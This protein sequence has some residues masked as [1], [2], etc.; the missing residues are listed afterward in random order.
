MEKMQCEN[1]KR[2]WMCV[3]TCCFIAMIPIA[4]TSCQTTPVPPFYLELVE[5]SPTPTND[6]PGNVL[7]EIDIQPNAKSGFPVTFAWMS[8][9]QGYSEQYP[10][11]FTAMTKWIVSERDAR[12]IQYILHTGD[13][14]DNYDDTVQ[15]DN[16]N[17]ALSILNGEV[18][19][20]VTAGNHDIH[21]V[22]QIYDFYLKYLGEKR[23]ETLPSFGGTY[24]NGRGRYDLI[25]IG[26]VP[27]ILLSV[28]YGMGYGVDDK[29]ID[30]INEVLQQ[31]SDRY[32]I[33]CFHSYLD[34]DGSLT[35]DGEVLFEKVV[36]KNQNVGLVLCGHR[37]GVNHTAVQFDDNLDGM[38]D[39]TVYQ[40]VAD[41][42]D[43]PK[44]GG[45]Y[46]GLLTFDSTER[47]ISVKTYSPYLDDYNCYEDK[48]E[49]E[50]FVLP[51]E[52]R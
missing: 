19:L 37:H 43:A 1:T 25:N 7:P 11:I 32:A 8:D 34:P 46:L 44:S 21:G 12:N 18:P 9:T 48:A 15:W 5:E 39:R 14:V 49:L 47:T 51:W 24:R 50:E 26:D 40:L 17:N 35:T 4:L 13:V 31:Y 45:G 38:P 52:F 36:K 23:F 16:A 33:L 20:F 2:K 22:N 28:G 42:Q 27:T 6:M 30:W 10:E 3:L 41:Y 29:A